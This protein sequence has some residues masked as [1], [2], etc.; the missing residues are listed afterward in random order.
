MK[1]KK[2]ISVA[3][4]G[5]N[6]DTA[7][8]LLKADEYILG[9]NV[10]TS[11]SQDGRI[12]QNEPSNYLGVVLPSTYKVI[13]FK[14]ND[15]S[16]RTYF[17]LTSDETN[18]NSPHFK[19]SSVGYTE[20]L[21]NESYNQDE[22]CLDCKNPK[23]IIGAPLET[24]VQSPTQ[25]FVELV[26]DRCIPLADI[27]TRGL[28]FDINF[29]IK[30]IEIKQEKLGTNLYWNDNRNYFRY[31]QVG[32]IEEALANNTFDY[33]HTLD[34]ACADPQETACL[35]VEKL[36]VSPKHTRIRLE[37]KEEQ[38]GGNLKQGTYEFWASYCDLYGNEITEYGTPT[39]PISIWDENNYIQSQTETDD[40]TNFAIKL[41]VHNLDKDS[42]K[43]YKIAVVERNNV[44]N[45]Q[46]V[47]LAGI[48]PTTDDTVIYSHSGS[49]NDD[50]YIAR[51]NVS[52]KKRMDFNTLTSIKAQYKKM[53]GTMVSDDRLFG[54]GLEE[55]QE[56]NLQP[57]V[58]LFSG[59]VKAQTSAVSE[60]LYK[61][62]IATSKYK[63]YPRN[64]VQPLAIRLLYNDGGYSAAFPF[65]GR[66]KTA[67]DAEL[68]ILTSGLLQ[69]DK[70]YVI[71][72]LETGDNFSNVGYVSEGTPFIA[73]GTTPTNW[74]NST[75][76]TDV[77]VAS[78]IAAETACVTNDRQE[79]WQIFNTASVIDTESCFDLDANSIELPP[80][81]VE[82]VCYVEIATVIPADTTTITDVEDYTTLEDYVN[83]NPEVVI[84][85]IT[86]YLED[87]YAETCTPTYV[88]DCTAPVL[89]TEVNEILEVVRETQVINYKADGEYLK[90]VIPQIC[91]PFKRS[92]TTA[93]L[94]E[95]ID[96]D[97]DLL[98][99]LDSTT[100]QKIYLRDGVF[101]NETCA[102]AISLPLQTDTAT[103]SNSLFFNYDIS[104]TLAD[105]L[106]S[107]ASF[108]TTVT[109]TG[110]YSSLHNKAQF[111]NV[112]KAG[113][114][115]IVLE[116]SKK[117]ACEGEGDVFATVNNKDVRYVIYDDCTTPTQLGGA[118]VDLT[119][120]SLTTLD[121]TTFPENFIIAVDCKITTESIPT[122][123]A[124]L[125]TVR[126]VYY[127]APP[128]GC[129]GFYQRNAEIASID[130]SWT[131]IKMR[132]RM[133]YVASCTST[134]P[135][136]NDCDPIP[137]KKYK[138]AYW[139]STVDYPDN[140]QL[141]DSSTLLIRP[142]DLSILS[143]D[144]KTDFLEYYTE[145]VNEFG[146]YT[147]KEATDL[148]CKPI[149]HPKLPDNTVSPF[150]IDNINH[151]ANA[152]SVIFPMGVNFDSKI[153]QTMIE[154]AYQN[155]LL[156]K[157]QKEK[158]SGW[159]I[160]KG[161]NS[162]HKSQISSGILYDVLDYTEKGEKIH[163]ANFPFNGL[164]ENKFV[165]DPTT[166]GL[167]QHP[168]GGLKNNKFTFLSPD[169]F[170]TRPA[171]PTEM[172]L[173]G[174]MFGSAKIDFA[175]VKEHAKW[176]VLGDKTYKTADTLSAAELFLE[177]TLTAADM[178]KEGWFS[179]GLSTGGNYGWI[180]ASGAVLAHLADAAL[181]L[182]EYRYKWLE[183]FR[184]LGRA[185][186]FAYMQYGVGKHN[187][188]L[189][190]DNEDDNCLRKLSLR[191]NLK[192]GYFTFVD[193]NNGLE[194]K[195]NNRLREN[196]I[197]LS[198]G[199]FDIEYPD[200]YINFDNNKADTKRSSN[201]VASEVEV[202]NPNRNIANPY[203]ALKNYIPDQW[204][205]I[206]SIKWLT[207]N[208]IFDLQEDTTCSPIYGGTQV[209]SRFSW[210]IKVPFFTDNAIRVADK[211]PYLY[212]KN[213]NIGNA[214]YYCNYETSEDSIFT[215]GLIP[216][217]FPD[218]RSTYNFD[219]TSGKRGFYL[220][221]PSKFYLYTHGIIDFL[222]ESEINCN[223]R[224]GK[225]EPKDQFYNGQDLAEH[226]QEVNLP[227]VYPNTFYY[228]NT[229][230]F[231]V[232]NTPNKKLDRTYDKEIWRKRGLKPNAWVWSEQDNNENSLV[233]PWLTFKPLNLIE[234][235]TD[236]GKLIDLRS[237]ESSQFL[238]RY[239][240]TYQLFNPANA[241]ADAIN[242]QNKEIGTGFLAARP[243]SSKKADLG[244]AGTQNTD[245]VSTPYGHFWVDAKRGRV[246]QVDQNG[247]NL[248]VISEA[249]QG[250]PSGKK[251][252]F[253]EHL[254][255]KILKQFPQADT[256]N[257]FKGLGLNMWYDS[258]FDRLFITKKDY[259]AINTDC[260]KYDDEIGFYEDCSTTEP[261]C[262]VGYAYNEE[263]QQCEIVATLP[264]TCPNG[265][266]YN[267]LT[268]MCEQASSC[269]AGLDIVFILDATGSQQTSIDNIKTAISTDII[270]AI[271]S[272][273]GADYRLG[274]IAVKDRR[275]AGQALFDILE[276]MGLINET[277]FLTQM[278][279][280]V[281]AGGA[282]SPE[283]TNTALEATL[284]NTPTVDMTGASLGG[285]TIGTFRTN[286]AKAI[287]LVTDNTPSSLDD[288]YTNEDWLNADLLSMQANAQGIQIFSYLTTSI[289]PAPTVPP[290]PSVTY[291]M[292]NYAT[293]TSGTYYFTPLGVGISDGVVD[294][295]VSG[296]E[297]PPPTQVSPV[298]VDGCTPVGA[299]CICTNTE[300]PAVV[301]I[302][303]PI[304]FDNTDYFR[305]LSWTI[306]Y[307]LTEGQWDSYFTFYPNFTISNLEHF[308]IGFNYGQDKGTIHNHTF[309]LSSFCVFQGRYEPF[310]VEFVVANENVNKILNSVSINV[311]AKRY[312][313]HYDDV[314][315]PNKGITDIYIYNS[316]NNSGNIVLHEQ[317]SLADERKYP[318]LENG[319]Q[320]ILSTFSE[321]K[322][323][324]NYLFNRTIN[325]A[326]GINHFIKDEN[327]IFKTINPRA[328][329]F[330]GKKVTERLRGE[331]F[332]IHLSNTQDSQFNI[333]IKNII[334]DET[335]TD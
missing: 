258:R 15:L 236:N 293:K 203:V 33:L 68:V 37:A 190:V 212:S 105:L 87:T 179:G 35:D 141:Y 121:I 261:T 322:Q 304:S 215:K 292:Q 135:K 178:V 111:F 181:R 250:K 301:G 199:D 174:Y 109:A 284:N 132:K 77:N 208:Y 57:V 43:Y 148:R 286:A 107:N 271:V 204:E 311:E 123:C 143:A 194:T 152:D 120:G 224:Y 73:T 104:E 79:K 81:D 278:A 71:L 153:V 142:S 159:E 180:A 206:D 225:K 273:F 331:N 184:N 200:D 275:F 287:I 211:T 163:F 115:K 38:I 29:P 263:T 220:R 242:S 133:E 192:D 170:Y 94:I 69:E 207:T 254:P 228:N 268:E 283:P 150:I 19:R 191:K 327:N 66:P 253:R 316:K 51:G 10:T 116:F 202:S 106:L 86:P 265:F 307:K 113:R 239:E 164:G 298:C 34:I 237:I 197:F 102:Y 30:K 313:N 260:L 262:S 276:P 255:F 24:I 266:T 227:I 12:I 26:N 274:L 88:G 125:M 177:V 126:P 144:D 4:R 1:Q 259:K 91:T 85:E 328:I 20:N 251:Q 280:I 217:S 183:T 267:P 308:Q 50:L 101:Q 218:I 168:Y 62:A 332:I 196:S 319:K 285:N 244:F 92:S 230:T 145:G 100:R 99:C 302:K 213:S 297:C 137:Y 272:N 282:N 31:L 58:N 64:E 320:H 136:V 16:N 248:E 82:K 289:E 232:S 264:A 226:L 205:T 243:V 23:N 18:I 299:E 162:V 7:I 189:K 3:N 39:N 269:E 329:S 318:Y 28:N 182:G 78:L 193:E 97:S 330:I 290:T 296:V 131:E 72:K 53:K 128:C 124:D 45:T 300:T 140:K 247:G 334:S 198:T 229:Y 166:G 221:P 129:F 306:S 139:E 171:I 127:V 167:I 326:N 160:L 321:G 8:S 173:Q 65:V 235:G 27:E 6:S 245:F 335:I 186:N 61:S 14:N 295:I 83:N 151:K 294:A 209:I 130:V 21:L 309:N 41:K 155:N 108:T 11:N 149:R 279:G 185:D 46:S 89:S 118:I 158:I 333:A 42:F 117:S 291:V 323:T 210:R 47:F 252:W 122:D 52:I 2:S 231:P 312:L 222:V 70:K 80:E 17:F 175:E 187:R 134:I 9:I 55:E 172:S 188:F 25:T 32:R 147:L 305:E 54:F 315:Y 317:K 76:V 219:S 288:L 22:E 246:F 233:D 60:N 277:S 310:V 270:P 281:A 214:V 112:T 201:F 176:T 13:G 234:E 169:M 75:V 119:T 257:K 93:A 5:M 40:Y 84:A 96:V 36:L 138:M 165:K 249:I 240:N 95:D 63:Q 156:T 223:F 98:L 74:T 146:A 195:V 67:E 241:V 103:S 114:D 44:G 161:D 90:S 48:Y 238:G 303:K 59:L 49:S 216:I 110:F 56:I 256:D 324:A 157:A 154:V 325:E 314:V